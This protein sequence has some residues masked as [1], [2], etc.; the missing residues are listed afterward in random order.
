VADALFAEWQPQYAERGIATFPVVGAEK[1]PAV[2]NY[3]RM[4]LRASCSLAA[5]FPGAMA[6]GL[7]CI[8]SRITILDVDTP[9]ER[10]LADVLS[11]F[12]PTPFIVRSGSGNFQAWYRHNGE[13]RRVKKPGERPIDILGDGFVVAPPSRGAKGTYTIVEGSLDDLPDLPVMRRSTT[14]TPAPRAI[15]GNWGRIQKGARNE[16]LFRSC[17]RAAPRC[18]SFDDLL[19][20][21]VMMNA[22]ELCEPLSD[23]EVAGVARSAW[24]YEISGTNFFD[25]RP[26]VAATFEEVD[27]LMD[28]N[29]DAYILLTK[30]RRRWRRGEHFAIANAMCATM[31]GGGWTPKR[32]AAARRALEEDYGKIRMVR[33]WSYQSP[34]CYELGD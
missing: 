21:A 19:W 5:R 28:Q 10:V 22:A 18:Q 12:G 2:G 27:D 4:G 26:R 29:P 8:P 13:K 16:A 32:F 24:G 9:D 14:K 34:A 3:L 15:Q 20:Q 11:E 6:F 30:L 7:A 25:G 1:R 33:R 17:M 31:P 23:A